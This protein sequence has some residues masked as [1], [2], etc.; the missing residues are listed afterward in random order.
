V[1]PVDGVVEGVHFSF[2]NVSL[3][4]I[5][6]RAASAQ[7]RRLSR[8]LQ[9]HRGHAV[10]YRELELSRSYDRLARVK[11][12]DI[13]V[14]LVRDTVAVVVRDGAV[15]LRRSLKAIREPSI[16]PDDCSTLLSLV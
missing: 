5:M 2:R 7:P 11:R 3:A 15:N 13:E 9:T 1:Q 4:E 6:G 16:T 12:V 10:L 14:S 8:L